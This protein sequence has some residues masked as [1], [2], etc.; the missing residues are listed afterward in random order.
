M[1]DRNIFAL[2]RTAPP[3][4]PAEAQRT[5]RHG[6]AWMRS[7]NLLCNTDEAT[8]YFDALGLG[9]L[10]AACSPRSR[11]EHLDVLTDLFCVL[12][13]I[14]DYFDGPAGDQLPLAQ[15]TIAELKDALAPSTTTAPVT[16][17]GRALA[18]VWF[19]S[20]A[21]MSESFRQRNLGNWHDFLNG[22]VSETMT[23][24]DDAPPDLDTY[25]V[26]RRSTISLPI[27]FAVMERAR[28]EELLTHLY[29]N[30]N[31]ERMRHLVMDI[32]AW[33]NDVQSLQH[34][35]RRGDMANLVLVLEHHTGC[36]R[37]QAIEQ[38]HTMVR[39]A[40]HEFQKLSTII[41]RVFATLGLR[42]DDARRTGNYATAL[43]D[44]MAACHVFGADSIRYQD[45]SR[46]RLGYALNFAPSETD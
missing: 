29:V 15:H 7:F 2:P 38:V 41:P 22:L 43:H 45:E 10:A 6:L 12:W 17:L 25:L 26:F 24:K 44:Y 23:R 39:D 3:C 5:Q 21:S 28:Q 27:F 16:P 36:T 31:I 19:R 8:R 37:I 30:A 34:E 4:D 14:D 13:A 42:P 35:V 1:P 20:T 33:S 40:Y 11:G 9:R 18:D 46:R 32:I